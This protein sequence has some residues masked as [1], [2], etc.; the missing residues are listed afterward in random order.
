MFSDKNPWDK[1][2]TADKTDW[3]LASTSAM[4]DRVSTFFVS[5]RQRWLDCPETVFSWPSSGLPF[6]PSTLLQSCDHFRTNPGFFCDLRNT[7]HPDSAHLHHSLR[8]LLALKILQKFVRRS[9]NFL[10]PVWTPQRLL[11]L[12]VHLHWM[13]PLSSALV[14]TVLIGFKTLFWRES[15]AKD[16]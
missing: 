10:L 5:S 6:Y 3:G 13:W 8:A 1:I 14:L 11:L 9:T 12:Y 7:C 2:V 16:N 4:T 15:I